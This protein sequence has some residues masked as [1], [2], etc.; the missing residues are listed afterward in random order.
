M[1]EPNGVGRMWSL[2]KMGGI[3]P[4]IASMLGSQHAHQMAQIRNM[5][6]TPR[7]TSALDSKLNE[8]EIVVFD[9]ETTG[10]STTNGDEI[11]SFGAVA[12]RDGKV[13][14]EEC[15]YSLVNP[16]RTIPPHIVELTGVTNEMV[17]DAPDLIHVL[18]AFMQFIG[19]RVLVA[20][21]SGH[22]KQFL[23]QA[24]WRTSKTNLNHRV[25]DTMMLAK[26]LE[27]GLVQYDLDT[28]L[29]RHNITIQNRHHAL[30]DSLMTAQL[31]LQYMSKVSEKKNIVT[32][33]DLYAYLSQH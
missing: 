18:S 8:M 31:W 30:Y 1:K 26:W 22:D 21:A 12:V 14:E 25:I 33:G 10:F 23:N 2:Y 17:E 3:T 9:L 19:R 20:H 13:L 28:L 24:L 5:S 4:A 27:P 32:L 29:E 7:K 15:F 16:K 11:I 6:R